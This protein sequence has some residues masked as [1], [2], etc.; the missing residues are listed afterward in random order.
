MSYKDVYRTSPATLGLVM[1]GY[2]C[3]TAKMRGCDAEKLDSYIKV[4][5]V[6]TK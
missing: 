5:F 3:Q 2:F 6:M 4:Y 1:I